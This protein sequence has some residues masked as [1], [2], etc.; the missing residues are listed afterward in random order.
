MNLNVQTRLAL[1]VHPF[2]PST[3]KAEAGGSEFEAGL[4]YRVPEQAPKLH[5]ESLSRKTKQKNAHI[6]HCLCETAYRT[7]P[8][9]EQTG[10]Q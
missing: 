4:C 5:R 1:V 6:A 8:T 2:N 10:R 7:T 3:L 9:H